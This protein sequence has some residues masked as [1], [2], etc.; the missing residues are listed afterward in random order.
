MTRAR[1][2]FRR[3]YPIFFSS[4]FHILS[5]RVDK[6]TVQTKTES[7]VDYAVTKA[8]LFTCNI[9]HEYTCVTSEYTWNKPINNTVVNMYNDIIDYNL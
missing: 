1:V 6:R 7:E 4:N 9:I 8:N 5:V 3:K 2:F